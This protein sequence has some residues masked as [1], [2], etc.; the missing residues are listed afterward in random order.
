M[1]IT[2]ILAPFQRFWTAHERALSVLIGQSNELEDL[3]Q[4]SKELK[5]ILAQIVKTSKGE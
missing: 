2:A 4:E 3:I 5:N 1:V